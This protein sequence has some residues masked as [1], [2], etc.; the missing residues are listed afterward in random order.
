MVI[1][2]QLEGL[3]MFAF[4]NQGNIPLDAYMGRASCLAGCRAP[5][6]DPEGPGDCLGILLIDCFAFRQS[7]VISIG[8]RDGAY[9]NAL[10]TAGAFCRIYKPRLLVDRSRKVSRNAFKI[11]KFGIG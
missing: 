5:L 7:L 2:E 1:P 9:L 4:I 10:S 3:G 11:Q 6:A 8:Q